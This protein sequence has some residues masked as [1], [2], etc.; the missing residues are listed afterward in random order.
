MVK[1]FF[2]LI[3]VFFVSFVYGQHTFWVTNTNDIGSGSLSQAI[4]NANNTS[5]LSGQPHRIKFQI[6]GASV[7]LPIDF[8]NRILTQH[9][10]IDGRNYNSDR[11]SF[12]NRR[13]VLTYPLRI[14][15]SA[16]VNASV[17]SGVAF[18]KIEHIDVR[19]FYK[20]NFY[21]G[22]ILLPGSKRIM[23]N[24]VFIGECKFGVIL[25][26]CS[27]VTIE[28]SYIG[29]NSTGTAYPNYDGI[30][31]TNSKNVIIGGESK[32]KGNVISNNDFKGIWIQEIYGLNGGG[33]LQGGE[34]TNI[35]IQ[36]NYIGT[37][38]SGNLPR[39]N[40][41][42]IWISQTQNITVSDNIISGN[43][44]VG[45]GLQLDVD[46]S[47][48][49]NN[50]VGL[51]AS[52][53]YELANDYG[54]VVRESNNVR[55]V[56]NAISGNTGVGIEVRDAD[57]G[58]VIDSNFIGT[59]T[60]TIMSFPNKVG[61]ELVQKNEP[62]GQPIDG[63]KNVQVRNNTIMY[64]EEG[65]VDV[66]GS[67]TYNNTITGNT[68][69]KDNGGLGIS[70]INSG[71]NNKSKPSVSSIRPISNSHVRIS[72]TSQAGDVIEI[73]ES[74]NVTGEFNAYNRTW[75]HTTA[76]SSGDWSVD[77]ADNSNGY[78][79]ATATDS[80]GNTSEFVKLEHDE[81]C[82]AGSVLTILS[83][84]CATGEPTTVELQ[85]LNWNEVD[86]PSVRVEVD[87]EKRRVAYDGIIDEFITTHTTD[88]K[89]KTFEKIY[90]VASPNFVLG[91]FTNFYRAPY[92]Y[93]IRAKIYDNETGELLE[94]LSSPDV[95]PHALGTCTRCEECVPSFNPLKGKK[96]LFSTWVT[97][98]T[99]AIDSYKDVEVWFNFGQSIPSVGPFKP[100][101]PIIEG[102]QKI[103]DTLI[104]PSNP[105][106]F[107]LEVKNTASSH[108]TVYVDDIRFHPFN[109]MMK[110]YVYDGETFRLMAEQDENNYS[111]F[112]EY[113]EEGGLIRTK[114]ETERGVL[115]LSE[116][117]SN[118][119]KK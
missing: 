39:P 68:I 84:G 72:G 91:E 14:D 2:L 53:S 23:I 11:S 46:D 25:N 40:K 49:E 21:G 97:Q 48:I 65:G 32:N 34:S 80:D 30:V 106:Y 100:S 108:V 17:S 15:N 31:V 16:R 83:D 60:G 90:N 64:N 59:N 74:D 35:T 117:R 54:I 73:F 69:A 109:A 3:G 38:P 93:Q 71:N 107:E 99:Q 62:S 116:S 7:L 88:P 28:S 67:N 9:T 18:V 22:I 105:E 43:S 61:I 57:N 10:Y 63:P 66:S 44:S 33:A 96:Y 5:L 87:F 118:L 55:V 36:N 12:D 47:D 102:W 103:E 104:I 42:G 86:F 56:R 37:D 111:T 98:S 20:N 51:N 115:T 70:L 112:Y 110:T 26:N 19:H 85:I 45:I 27:D 75:V 101:G 8:D 58:V 76:N 77:I 81:N 119:T 114:K 94:C 41:D 78:F 24:D 113:D 6:S 4:I 13:V 92:N 29:V 1:Y 89:E 52:S 50:I 95:L 79:I 82:S